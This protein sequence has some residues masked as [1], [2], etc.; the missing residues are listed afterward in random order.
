M[1]RFVFA[2]EGRYGA[3]ELVGDVGEDGGAAGGDF[4]LREEEEQAREEVVDLDGGGEVVEVG[5]EGG[6]DFDGIVLICGQ[7]SV[8]RAE[9]WVD[10]GRVETAA[11]AVGIEID[12]TSGVVDE[13]GFS[14]LLGHLVL[15][16]RDG[17]GNNRGQRRRC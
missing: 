12:A 6:G 16:L 9:G 13:A 11:P 8:R 4:V 7:R 3:E 1:L 15:P 14:G 17:F 2:V 5:G 10:V